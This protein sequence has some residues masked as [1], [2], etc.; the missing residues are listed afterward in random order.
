MLFAIVATI[1]LTA[2]VCGGR[3]QIG[4]ATFPGGSIAG[5]TED[6]THIV[7]Q[8][9]TDGNAWA[10]VSNIRAQLIFDRQPCPNLEYPR[11]CI[12][13]EPHSPLHDQS[14]PEPGDWRCEG[15]ECVAEIHFTVPSKATKAAKTDWDVA[16]SW[17]SSSDDRAVHVDAASVVDAHQGIEVFTGRSV[18]DPAETATWIYRVI[19]DPAIVDRP[20]GN[21]VMTATIT[22]L[23]CDACDR[24]DATVRVEEPSEL[25]DRRTS[26]THE[27]AEHVRS[28]EASRST[29]IEE[30]DCAGGRC[31]ADVPFTVAHE[32]QLSGP[33]RI[34][35]AVEFR[36]I[37]PA[38]HT[39]SSIEEILYFDGPPPLGCTMR[40]DDFQPVTVGPLEPG[41]RRRW[42]P[43]D[44]TELSVWYKDDSIVEAH[45]ERF[46][47]T[48][49]K[50]RNVD[51]L[52]D[53][54]TI[55]SRDNLI[56]LYDITCDIYS[57]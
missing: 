50:A 42:H 17:R 25:V 1:L 51:V 56:P 8:L 57:P 31:V 10:T 49:T 29:Y 9:R 36:W 53:N 3:S 7:V 40:F 52:S 5:P 47:D 14:A 16:V 39:V 18:I 26:S 24:G 27:A 54:P 30:F 32:N 41:D 37:L 20:F 38:S 21:I 33:L 2:S 13:P 4:S 15:E 34:A 6:D 28:G 35:W 11:D 45:Y 46:G 44:K 43:K 55:L 12:S 19:T 22:D 48:S 23:D